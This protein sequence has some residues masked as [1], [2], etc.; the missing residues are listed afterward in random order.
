MAMFPASIPHYFIDR[1][2]REGDLEFMRVALGAMSRAL[3][4]DGVC[5]VVIGDVKGLNLAETVWDEVGKGTGL[6]KYG[7]VADALE[8]E[9]KVTR[10][11]GGR[12]GFATDVDRFLILY[13]GT[14]EPVK[15]KVDWRIR[16][17]SRDRGTPLDAYG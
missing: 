15:A 17:P 11:R 4:P 8:G 12:R 7:V 10:I 9:E 1:F 6:R 5:V 14:I 2:T 13:K 3:A 16:Y